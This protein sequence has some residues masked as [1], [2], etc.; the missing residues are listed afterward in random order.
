MKSRK[1]VNGSPDRE[2]RLCCWWRRL[3]CSKSKCFDYFVAVHIMV[4]QFLVKYYKPLGQFTVVNMTVMAILITA[5]LY[6]NHH[7]SLLLFEISAH[8][9]FLHRFQILLTWCF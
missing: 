2:V 6:H 8:E 9:T 7:V 3:R 4:V 1:L 5:V